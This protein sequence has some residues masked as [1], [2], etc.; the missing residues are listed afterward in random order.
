M[1]HH[2]PKTHDNPNYLKPLELYFFLG[3]IPEPSWNHGIFFFHRDAPAKHP[4]EEAAAPI[5][6]RQGDDVGANG[7]GGN[8]G[9]DDGDGPGSGPHGEGHEM[10]PRE[11]NTDSLNGIE[12]DVVSIPEDDGEE[13]DGEEHD[14]EEHDGEGL[15]SE[16]A[17]RLAR[18]KSSVDLMMVD[19]QP[20]PP[21][22]PEP[23]VPPTQASPEPL[24]EDDVVSEDD[25]IAPS[26][27]KYTP[28]D[29]ALPLFPNDSEETSRSQARAHDEP[30]EP[31][32]PVAK[33][34]KKLDVLVKERENLTLSGI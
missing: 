28:E 23:P 3:T 16:E 24:N 30:D 2:F 5:A 19:T 22:S 8:G 31:D 33:L 21:A 26:D 25:D 18:L 20:F 32:D 13:H 14:G 15:V 9:E 11:N 34:Q 4:G 10:I 6:D 12:N 17:H 29:K 1:F 27:R 7:S